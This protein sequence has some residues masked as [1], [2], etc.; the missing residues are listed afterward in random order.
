MGI[1]NLWESSSI[2]DENQMSRSNGAIVVFGDAS[3][4]QSLIAALE[5]RPTLPADPSLLPQD[6]GAQLKQEQLLAEES[7]GLLTAQEAFNKCILENWARGSFHTGFG[8]EHLI[9]TQASYGWSLAFCFD[10]ESM[11]R[12]I[13]CLACCMLQ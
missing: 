9:D 7:N 5:G 12:W 8:S 10:C 3:D 11:N 6:P 1:R 2:V 4:P 13:G